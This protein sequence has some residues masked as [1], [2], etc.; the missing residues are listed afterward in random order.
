[1]KLTANFNFFNEQNGNQSMQDAD[2]DTR[3]AFVLQRLD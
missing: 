3:S 2:L 1:M